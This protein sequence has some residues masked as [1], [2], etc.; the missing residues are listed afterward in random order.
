MLLLSAQSVSKSF[1]SRQV[2]SGLSLTVNAGERVGII[3]PN[4]S[5]KSTLLQILAGLQDPDDGEVALRKGVK[6][7]YVPQ[8]P[9]FDP[10]Q[11]VY[12]VL[13]A[14]CPPGE[15]HERLTAI[16]QALGRAQFTDGEAQT[17]TLSGGWRK[18]LAVARAL[19]QAP[20]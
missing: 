12:G 16:H 18:R 15:E 9:Q 20:D 7:T 8:D 11:T 10:G 17:Q 19:I 2:F 6:L 4:G 14:A 3:G 5:G 1:S 13:E